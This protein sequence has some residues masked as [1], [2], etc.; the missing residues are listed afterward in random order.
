MRCDM[1]SGLDWVENTLTNALKACP[2][3]DRAII[4]VRGEGPII[5]VRVE[6]IVETEDYIRLRNC[7]EITSRYQ[8][9]SGIAV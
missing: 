7:P 9:E 6:G 4:R 1:N 8:I 3:A 5:R 2:R